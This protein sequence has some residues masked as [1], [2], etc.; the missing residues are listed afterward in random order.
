MVATNEAWERETARAEA[1]DDEIDLGQYARIL[2]RRWLPALLVLLSTMGLAGAYSWWKLQNAPVFE[3]SSKFLYETGG[4]QP[5]LQLPG[6]AQQLVGG[7]SQSSGLSNQIEILQSRPLAQKVVDKLGLTNKQGEPLDPDALL[8]QI[9]VEQVEST[10]IIKLSAQ[11]NQPQQAARIT[12]TLMDIYQ[13]RTISEQTADSRNTRQFLESQIPQV[14]REVRQAE[15]AL[16][17]FKERN[18]IVSLEEETGA[19]VSTL[20]QLSQQITNIRADLE[21]AESRLAALRQKVGMDSGQALASAQLSQS[22]SVQQA[23]EQL[24]EVE[25]ELASQQGELTSQ[26][27][28][29]QTLQERRSRLRG[30]LRERVRASLAGG[31]AAGNRNLQLG[32]TKVGLIDSLVNAEVERLGA[33]SKLAA[34]QQVRDAYQARANQLPQLEQRRA[35]LEREL[36]TVRSTLKGLV[37]QLQKTRIEENRKSSPVD[38][39]ERAQVPGG[40]VS[41]KIALNLALGGVLGALLGGAAAFALDARDRRIHSAED[42]QQILGYP[43]LGSVPNFDD[44]PATEGPRTPHP[45]AEPADTPSRAN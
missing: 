17:R 38:V 26:H 7:Q 36:Q 39:V 6:A 23:L 37:E 15:A 25:T 41:P 3:S 13:Q 28:A 29:I 30:L 19:T 12:N 42:A 14:R 34:L 1:E 27:P 31:E 9:Q 18:N 24:Q 4:S 35:Q 21:G 16:R 22:P 8:G 40:P 20:Q 11:S 2:K 33:Q 44:V 45:E 5:A 10:N 43:M 32:S